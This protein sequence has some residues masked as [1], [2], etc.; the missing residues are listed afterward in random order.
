MEFNVE[1]LNNDKLSESD[2]AKQD[3][4][5]EVKYLK[6]VIKNED[7]LRGTYK[8]L[9]FYYDT[10][11]FPKGWR[12]I[13][14]KMRKSEVDKN[15]L[16]WAL[17]K[18]EQI[19]HLYATII[20][21]HIQSR[22]ER[23]ERV[24]KEENRSDWDIYSENESTPEKFEEFLLSEEWMQILTDEIN[25]HLDKDGQAYDN[26]KVTSEILELKLRTARFDKIY[27]EYSLEYLVDW[28]DEKE[29]RMRQS[30]NIVL[31]N[32][33][34]KIWDY[35]KMWWDKRWRWL[36]SNIDWLFNDE[37]NWLS[38]AELQESDFNKDQLRWLLKNKI[39]RYAGRI[40]KLR[41]RENIWQYLWNAELDLQLKSYLYIYGKFFY[42]E[43]FNKPWYELSD[44]ESTLLEI[45]EAILHYDGKLEDV[46]NNKFLERERQAENARKERERLRIQ[47]IAKRNRERNERAQSLRKMDKLNIGEV[48][49]KSMDPNSATWPEIAAEANLWE[50]LNDYNL[51][52]Q[53]SEAS[54]QWKKEATF[55]AAWKEFI[56]SHSDI[57][58]LITQEQMRIL[59]DINNNTI[60]YSALE[61][62]VKYNPLLKDMTPE[63]VEEI[64]IKLSSF[65]STFTNAENKLLENSSE[66]R[67]NVGETMRTYAIWAVIDNVR[68][69]FNTINWWQNWDFKWFNLNI[70][71][72]A[73]REWNDI[74]ISWTFNGAEVKV[75]YDLNTWKLFMNSFLN[76]LTPEKVSIWESS[77]VDYP[78]WTIRPFNDVLND[79]YKL[80]PRSTKNT[81]IQSWSQSWGRLWINITSH[82]LHLHNSNEQWNSPQSD[83]LPN[84][85]P[86]HRPVISSH[87]PKIDRSDI[88]SRRS[89]V[90][91]LL[92]SQINLIGDTIKNNTESQAQKNSAISKFM[93]T[94][95]VISDN[96]QFSSWDFNK[97]S[98]LY[99]LI[100]II[101]KTGDP[102]KGDIQALE[103]FNNT[104][105]PTVI[106][107]SWL[108]WWT[109]NEHQDKNNK[110]SE[111]IFNYNWD[112]KNIQC[113]R[114][115]TKDFNPSQF[116]WIAN[117]ES[118][119][120]LWFADLVKEKL[121]TWNELNRKLDI[122][123]MES[124]IK[125]IETVDK[126]VDKDANKKLEEQ[127]ANIN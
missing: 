83:D 109:R 44:Y 4:H 38:L 35:L 14:L 48:Q 29:N 90:Q 73:I 82:Q 34:D 76:R 99:D 110:K 71:K 126:E 118:S 27:R 31:N 123:K 47:E 55:R 54:L 89:E 67:K 5:E 93:K 19:Q 121:I 53:E 10:S 65:S 77:S 117:F 95:N 88:D 37:E 51:D 103:Y 111:K 63:E 15:S 45:F 3:F 87:I 72:P 116:S 21:W 17:L 33:D 24:K 2:R 80:P 41:K 39:Q 42:P 12:D 46:K 107:Y 106:D 78:I 70:E 7:N 57:K 68:D 102:E 49:T 13:I 18:N 59:F 108:N 91:E 1:S 26:Y 113:L 114:D 50:Q 86:I 122:S 43:E 52:V 75:R 9:N 6:E 32:V 40:L 58:S 124:F 120:Q 119:H 104:F 127:L 94:F 92:N 62:F 100:D 112:N 22:N 64:R 98:N 11:V 79:F 36:L 115:N 23:L 60:N 25:R 74:I 61:R 85:R 84:S 69:T 66:M 56:E 81:A 30:I 20:S 97:W 16:E 105:M 101:E 8:K 28:V 96:W 125:D